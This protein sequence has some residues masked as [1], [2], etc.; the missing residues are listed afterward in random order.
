M[1]FLG[2]FRERLRDHPEDVEGGGLLVKPL[3]RELEGPGVLSSC[4]KLDLKVEKA[5]G[6][7]FGVL[8]W[9]VEVKPSGSEALFEV[10]VKP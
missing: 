9:K 10:E 8:L 3:K 1:R 5:K 7:I 2:G 6:K 4:L